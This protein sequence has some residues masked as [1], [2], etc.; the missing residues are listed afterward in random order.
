MLVYF[1]DERSVGPDH[2]DRQFPHGTEALISKV[3][4]AAD[5]VFRIKGEYK[6]TERAALEYEQA[7]ST[8]LK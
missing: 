5:Q 3:P 1:G 6:D 7:L 8:G 4:L 2:A